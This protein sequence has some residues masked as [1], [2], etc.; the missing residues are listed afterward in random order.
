MY[1]HQHATCF[2]SF[3]SPTGNF[4][5]DIAKQNCV[6]QYEIFII[7]ATDQLNAQILVFLLS[8]LY[9]STC[10]EHCCAH[11]QEVKIVLHSIWYRHTV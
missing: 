1:L 3:E 6:L 9:S 7:L 4:I 2:G 5:A 10:F 11:H 8:L